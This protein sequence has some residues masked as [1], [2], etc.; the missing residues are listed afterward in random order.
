MAE[1]VFNK[2]IEPQ[3]KAEIEKYLNPLLWLVP[4]WCQ[5]IHLN[6]YDA[7]DETAIDTTVD[8]EYRRITLN[9]YSSWLT[10][11][12]TL[13]QDNVIHECVHFCVNELYHQ[14]QRIVT[15][16]C[17]NNEQLKYYAFEQLKISV[18]AVTQDLCY[19]IMNKLNESKANLQNKT[20]V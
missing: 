14:A 8:Y 15:A 3:N 11:T 13:K 7:N 18:E 12:P 17:E 10:Q 4:K 2:N 9:F 5:A 20:S 1:I 16:T 6:L 19:A